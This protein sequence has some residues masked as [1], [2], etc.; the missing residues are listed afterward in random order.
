MIPYEDFVYLEKEDDRYKVSKDAMLSLLPGEPDSEWTPDMWRALLYIHPYQLR[1]TFNVE[2]HDLRL[3]S[4]QE[5]TDL[6][7]KKRE[8][9]SLLVT[10]QEN[11]KIAYSI[12]DCQKKC[13]AHGCTG[14]KTEDAELDPR[15]DDLHHN[16]A[17]DEDG[18]RHLKMIKVRVEHFLWKQLLI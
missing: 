12:L 14:L 8:G 9:L 10:L 17:T 13:F 16:W 5:Y 7:Q 18:W 3:L 11:P 4:D 15:M 6:I 1:K 2:V